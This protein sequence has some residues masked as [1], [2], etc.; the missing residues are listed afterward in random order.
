MGNNFRTI[1]RQGNQTERRVFNFGSFAK[2]SVFATAATSLI[3]GWDWTRENIIPTIATAFTGSQIEQML[4]NNNIGG[5]IGTGIGFGYEVVK[6]A[7]NGS[8]SIETL[9]R[10]SLTATILRAA[11]EVVQR[12][13]ENPNTILPTLGGSGGGAL[14]GYVGNLLM[15][16]G[17]TVGQSAE[18]VGL[19]ATLGGI[20]VSDVQNRRALDEIGVVGGT[21]AAFLFKLYE[22]GQINH[23]TFELATKSAMFARALVATI[24]DSKSGELNQ[25][26]DLFKSGQ[27]FPDNQGN[28]SQAQSRPVRPVVITSVYRSPNQQQPEEMGEWRPISR[29]RSG[30][31][32]KIEDSEFDEK[33]DGFSEEGDGVE[34]EGV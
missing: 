30:Q 9:F 26:V 2:N 22:G 17:M 14:L 11:G 18:V 1:T 33:G 8:F 25:I 29:S 34:E 12:G 24:A 7:V 6:D 3:Q 5:I 32:L 4:R 16:P 23:E 31:A 15:A 19:G 27:T 21:L 20:L 10:A 28:N 13:I